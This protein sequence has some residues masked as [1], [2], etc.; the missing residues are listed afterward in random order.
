MKTENKTDL[1]RAKQLTE[2]QQLL[3]SRYY[4]GECGVLARFKAKRLTQ[5]N[6]TACDFINEL[7]TLHTTCL[8]QSTQ[9]I[10]TTRDMW[11]AVSARIEQETRS[12]QYLGARTPPPQREGMWERLS[13]AS[14][15]AGGLSGA[16]LAALALVVWYKPV[17]ILSFSAPQAALVTTPN[18]VQPVGIGGMQTQPRRQYRVTA[19]SSNIR[20]PL[21]VDWMRSSGSL[22]LI[23]DPT[24]SSAII[25]IRRREATPINANAQ[26]SSKPNIRGKAI[27]R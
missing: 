19:A 4:D 14:A 26:T 27:T 10:P 12:A 24:G 25:W 11:S 9:T 5:N 22:K 16:A 2:R 23:P 17:E 15:F 20:N 7:A 8:E 6:P 18:L 3:L 13:T 1:K 21:E